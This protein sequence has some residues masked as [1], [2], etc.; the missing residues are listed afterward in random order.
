[1]LN[2]ALFISGRLTCY[3]S[4][5]IPLLI[6]LSKTYNI[7]LFLSINSKENT[8]AINLLIDI[9][10][11]YEFKP[12]FYDEDWI[13][14]RLNNNKKYM[15]PYNQL[16]M[17]YNDLNNFNLIEKYEQDNN[18]NF[19]VICKIRPDMIFNN[20]NQINFVK[21]HENSLILYNVDL[22]CTIR[23]FGN[24][25]PLVSDAF[26]FGNKKSM[27]IYC[28][29]YNWIKEKDIELKG[30]YNSTFEPY[31]NDNLFEYLF[32]NPLIKNNQLTYEEYENI[33]FNNK[34]GLSIKYLPWKYRLSNERQIFDKSNQP[35]EGRIINEQEYVWKN[36]WCGLIHK[37]FKFETN[38]YC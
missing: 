3:K 29:T 6:H 28:N 16:S 17:F 18:I 27:K 10:G 21:D 1:M 9:L 8:E 15:G 5:L 33:M 25:P 31:L 19:D 12:F 32:Y 4:V 13:Q 11:Y 34:R 22:A 30:N 14:N 7:K 35:V 26:C 23:W 2:I 36:E 20:L 38:L 24:S 37:D